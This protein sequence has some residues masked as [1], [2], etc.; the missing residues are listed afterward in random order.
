MKINKPYAN[1]SFPRFDSQDICLNDSNFENDFQISLILKT[2][3]GTPKIPKKSCKTPPRTSK[4][5][6]SCLPGLSKTLQ[7]LPRCKRTF[8]ETSQ[9]AARAS[10]GHPPSPPELPEV[11][12]LLPFLLASLIPPLSCILELPHYLKW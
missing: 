9:A 12:V 10:R 5:L 3:P 7:E 2:P 4:M 1:T 11:H 8:P 6:P